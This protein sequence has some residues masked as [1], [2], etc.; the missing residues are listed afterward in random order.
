MM[1]FLFSFASYGLSSY[2]WYLLGGFSVA[3]Q[4]LSGN[5]RRESKEDFKNV[6]TVRVPRFN[7]LA[8]G[9]RQ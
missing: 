5:E 2:E 4:K 3:M 9:Q 1:N 6:S 8:S 7:A